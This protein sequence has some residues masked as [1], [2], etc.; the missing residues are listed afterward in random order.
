MAGETSQGNVGPNQDTV[1]V[2]ARRELGRAFSEAR[3]VAPASL[4]PFQDPTRNT[5][6]QSF[7][8]NSLKAKDGGIFYSQQKCIF[9]KKRRKRFAV[10]AGSATSVDSSA[11]PQ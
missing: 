10:F 2:L 7:S 9:L 3:R 6:S 11:S 4:L 1:V 8:A 5:R